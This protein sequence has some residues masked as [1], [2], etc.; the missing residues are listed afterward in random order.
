MLSLEVR[1]RA[2]GAEVHRL[3]GDA[4][5][6]GAS[7]GNEV[8][9]RARGVAGRHVRIFERNGRYH[10]GLYKGVDAVNVNGQEF[11]GG[12][13]APGDRITIGEAT[14]TVLQMLPPL[15]HTP[16]NELPLTDT[17]VPVPLTSAPTTEVEYRAMRLEAYR[18]CRDA[19]SP[20]DLA[21][22]LTDFLEQ[23]FEPTEWAMGELSSNGFRPLS[24]T[25]LEAPATPPRLLEDARAG[26]RVARAEI[27]TGVLTLVTEPL[28]DNA[29]SMAILVRETPRLPARGILLLEELVEVAGLAHAAGR[30]TAAVESAALHPAPEGARPVGEWSNAD[31][32]LHQT[33]DLKKIIETV[34]REVIDRA[35]CRV[36]GNQSRGAEILNISRGSL[37]AKLK[38][39][40]IQDYRYLRR[41]RRKN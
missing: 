8:V 40:G 35:M 31:A 14:I 23:Q 41:A 36:E 15:R 29:S 10:L 17:A 3:I 7:S 1:K 39:Y 9:V 28:R 27:V 16:I 12:P 18:I 2:G 26:E 30:K 11:T 33:D 19:A 13:I 22:R 34:E 37:I 20:E 4:F 6:V 24:S 38:E 25:F 21:T 5:T 32:I